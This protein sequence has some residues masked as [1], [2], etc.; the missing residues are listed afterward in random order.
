[1]ILPAIFLPAIVPHPSRLVSHPF[2][3]LLRLLKL[4]AQLLNLIAIGY[5]HSTAISD[6]NRHSSA[7]VKSHLSE[8][9]AGQLERQCV[10]IAVLR[11]VSCSTAMKL[12]QR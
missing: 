4:P 1:M 2:N 7:G 9:L 8:P 12:A 10:G 6:P 5:R 3:H 11:A